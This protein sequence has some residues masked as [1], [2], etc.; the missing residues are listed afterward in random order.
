MVKCGS[1]GDGKKSRIGAAQLGPINRL[2]AENTVFTL[3]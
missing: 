2:C 1:N 3:L